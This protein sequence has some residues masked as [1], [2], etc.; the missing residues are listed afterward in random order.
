[1]TD[2]AGVIQDVNPAFERITGYNRQEVIG[3]DTRLLQSG[4]QGPEFY[5]RM[6]SEIRSTGHWRGEIWN[7]KKSGEVYPEI[8]SISALRDDDGQIRRYIAIFLDISS[9]KEK[10]DE[11]RK[12]AFY[13]PLTGLPNR[14][15]AGDRLRQSTALHHR[16]GRVLALAYIDLDGFKEINDQFGHQVGDQVLIKLSDNMRRSLRESD[17]LARIGGDEFLAILPDLHAQADVEVL[18]SRLMDAARQAIP[19]QGQMLS[20]SASMGISFYPQAQALDSDQLIRQADQ[21][22]YQ[23]KVSGKNCYKLF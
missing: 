20:L 14:S 2:Q 10:E 16:N 18:A 7:R 11:L 15:L 4:L 19:H 6:W 13:D 3:R 9:L 17:T 23:A 21:A 22:M 8:L 1:M 12:L 5:E